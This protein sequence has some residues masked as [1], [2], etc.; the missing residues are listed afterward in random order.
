M[1]KTT[2]AEEAQQ[3]CEDLQ[4]ILQLI[5]KTKQNKTK[6]KQT[7]IK[8]QDVLF[9]IGDWIAKVGSPEIPGITGKFGLGVQNEARQ[10]LTDF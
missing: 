10:R 4:D 6:N 1:P 9:M 3:F 5:P 8:N 7:N 2:N